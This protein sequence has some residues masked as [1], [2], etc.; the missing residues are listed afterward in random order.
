MGATGRRF[1]SENYLKPSFLSGLGCHHFKSLIR[2]SHSSGRD[3]VSWEAAG[4]A[5]APWGSRRVVAGTWGRWKSLFLVL[6]RLKQ[7]AKGKDQ[8]LCLLSPEVI[9]RERK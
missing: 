6:T 5:P 3:R 4:E 7:G 1:L 2:C 8:R 9:S